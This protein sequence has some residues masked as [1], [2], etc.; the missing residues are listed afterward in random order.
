M[1]LQEWL[2]ETKAGFE[3][4][5][6][7]AALEV[8]HRATENLLKSGA[9]DTVLKP[10]DAMPEFELLNL[11]GEMIKSSQLLGDGKLVVG[12]YRGVW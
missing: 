4:Q 3:R 11:Q 7:A 6:P 12:F 8:M 1:K 10:G 2:D 9:M 5:A